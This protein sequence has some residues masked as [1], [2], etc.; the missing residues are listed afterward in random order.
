MHIRGENVWRGMVLLITISLLSAPI[1]SSLGYT[2]SIN[3]TTSTNHYKPFDTRKILQNISTL[4]QTELYTICDNIS[5]IHQIT[6]GT[7]N[8]ID[9]DNDENTGVN[10]KDIKV[11][12]LLLP[13]FSTENGL[14]IGINLILNIDQLGE[15]IKDKDFTTYIKINNIE[16]GFRSPH[17]AESE[18]PEK[19]Q[20]SSTIF[21]NLLDSTYGLKFT[22]NPYYSSNI[23][24]KTILFF[25]KY[26]DSST[27]QEYIFSLEPAVSTEIK[28]SSTKDPGIW[29]YSFKRN[30]NINTILKTHIIK[31]SLEDTKDTIMTIKYLPREISFKFSIQPFKKNGG[32]ILYQSKNDYTTEIQIESNKTGKCRYTIIKNPPKKIYA[33]WIP[34]KNNGYLKLITQ[35]TEA[36][37]ITLQNQLINP[38]INISLKNIRNVDFK[39]YW[40]LTNPGTF[41]II[42][43]SSINLDIHSFI[44]EWETRINITSL[45]KN[46]D[47]KWKLNTTGYIFYNTNLE[48]IKTVDLLIKTNTIGIRTKADIFKAEDFKLNWDEN[49]NIT[50]SGRID[51]S[52]IS[53][54][55]YLN[56]KWYH[57]WPWT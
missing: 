29:E 9:V 47:I 31:H 20:L 45:S 21:L 55:I 15:E 48:S 32:K 40:N 50:S 6:F 34:T 56:G 8:E 39:S 1:V 44:E 57:I 10:G 18:I 14:S 16:I 19:L 35:S 46:L 41:K 37:S 25:T 38:T 23:N 51:F 42:R 22:S 13:W 30:S 52:T 12:Y 36:T 24:K 5:K 11:Q 17:I 28:I 26:N 54:D 43:N 2:N 33:E 27:R 3:Y 53:I 7:Y 4:L 49:W